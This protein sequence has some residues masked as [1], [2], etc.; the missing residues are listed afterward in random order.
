MR[1]VLFPNRSRNWKVQNCAVVLW[2]SLKN[3]N[4]KW[5]MLT[6]SL[7]GVRRCLFLHQLR[8]E[9][10]QRTDWAR[11]KVSRAW[12]D[13][14]C[15][16]GGWCLEQLQGTSENPRRDE[17][18]Q[19]I[20]DAESIL[21]AADNRNSLISWGRQHTRLSR[22]SEEAQIR[23][24]P[25]LELLCVRPDSSWTCAWYHSGRCPDQI[26]PVNIVVWWWLD[27]KSGRCPDCIYGCKF[28]DV[29]F[30]SAPGIP[31]MCTSSLVMIHLFKYHNWVRRKGKG[32]LLLEFSLTSM[33]FKMQMPTKLI[34]KK[35]TSSLATLLFHIRTAPTSIST[36]GMPLTPTRAT[37]FPNSSSTTGSLSL[38]VSVSSFMKQ[39]KSSHLQ[40]H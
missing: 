19:T 17:Q 40:N 15:I 10:M 25:R 38:A 24:V 20:L 5:K 14:P 29:L 27:M 2:R 39:R 36:I 12:R 8:T 32:F 22:L 7:A 11:K 6:R 23:S 30:Y 33:A 34:I 18:K 16:F 13:W 9:W 1:K 4:K 28:V 35:S 26:A 3:S 37:F 31:P 21:K